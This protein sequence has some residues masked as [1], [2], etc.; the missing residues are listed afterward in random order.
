MVVGGWNFST[1]ANSGINTSSF[2]DVGQF[3]VGSM[4][5]APLPAGLS[6]RSTV[7]FVPLIISIAQTRNEKDIR[8]RFQ[9]RT[10][11]DSNDGV[12]GFQTVV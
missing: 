6:L 5:R 3:D 10:L 11:D 12:S 9:F 7:S 4:A 1:N 8:E 2:S